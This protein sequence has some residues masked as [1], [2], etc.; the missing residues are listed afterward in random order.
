MT[1][2]PM[3]V[4]NVQ[5]A[6]PST[7]MPT[8]SE[9]T[10]L[11]MAMYGRHG[12]CPIPIIAP[13]SP[14]DCFNCIIEAFRIALQY[15]TP[16]ILLS[17]GF[18]AMGAEPWLLPN[19]DD[20]NIEKPN[21]HTDPDGFSPYTRDPET[22]ARLW[23]IPG[24]PGL[25]H[26]IGGIEKDS[27]TGDISY[28]PENHNKM[29]NL[30]ANKIKGI[31]KS[32]PPLE[33]TGSEEGEILVVGWGSTYGSILTAVEELQTAGQSVSAIHLRYLYPFQNDLGEILKRYKKILVPELNLGQ[34]CQLIRAEFLVDAI[35]F[36]KVTGKP[37]L[38]SELRE[39]ILKLL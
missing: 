4:V 1:E 8:K 37:F 31:A 5:R 9:Q 18:L 32:L 12:E 16:V 17:D 27:I 2:L 19:V 39:C 20:I 15:M 29:V 33:I 13:R 24:T 25:E 34:L 26:R 11:L 30:R 21:F 14:S 35:P 38:V 3:V 28:D 36:N 7:G 22:L 6:G 23:A 10:D